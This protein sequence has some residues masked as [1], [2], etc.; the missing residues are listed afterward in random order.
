M[1]NIEEV[2]KLR[3]LSGAGFKDCLSALNEAK[4]NLDK[5]LEIL[6]V[7]GISKAS[8]TMARTANEGIVVICGDKDKSS[9][10]EI[11]CETDFVAKNQDFVNFAKEVGEIN[12]KVDSRKEKLN[13]TLMKNNKSVEENLVALIS[14]IG[15][16]ISLGRNKTIKANSGKIY[17]YHHSIVQD[18]L[19]KL[20]VII[21]LEA[22][23]FDEKID[24]IGKQISMH[25]AAMDPLALSS[26]LIDEDIIKKEKELIIEELKNSGKPDNIIEKISL[27][28]LS[29]FKEDS[30]LLSQGWVMDPKKKLSEIL[31]ETD[32]SLKILDFKRLKI[33]EGV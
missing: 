11:N 17:S 23:K 14:K 32:N 31:K 29:K 2:K 18:N 21:C 24:L 8:K 13:S 30:S 33:G 28:K 9:I 7:K 6:R 27:G 20:G 3:K 22:S 25:V 4:G 26:D 16:K 15:E 10:L 12:N 1:S 5:A 19:S